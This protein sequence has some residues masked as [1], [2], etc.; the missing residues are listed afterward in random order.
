MKSLTFQNF[1]PALVVSMFLV[2]PAGY[3]AVLE[4][5]VVTAQKRAE[6]LQDVPLAVTAYSGEEL[7][8]FGITNTQ[9]L[10]HVTASLLFHN[11]SSIAQPRI[12]GVGTILSLLGLEPS[13]AL[14]V[15]DQYYSRPI[16]AMMELP[17]VERIEILKGPQGTLYGRNATGGAIRIV[18]RDP[19]SEFGGRLNLS[20][21]N[22]GY[23]GG[24]LYVE[25]GL[26]ETLRASFST[27][28][29]DRDGFADNLAPDAGDV[30]DLNVQMYRGKLVW[31]A[32]DRVTAKLAIDYTDKEDTQGA[33]TFDIS[34]GGLSTSRVFRLPTGTDRED[35]YNDHDEDNEVENFNTQLR[36][37]ISFDA[38]DLVSITTYQD[39]TGGIG[40][41]F[42]AS[43]GPVVHTYSEENVES[44]SQE[45]QLISTGEG[46]LEWLLG[47]Y[48]LDSDGDFLLTIDRTVLA[49]VGLPVP[50][51]APLPRAD[52]K[53]EAW[54]IFGQATWNF[55]EQWGLTA[56]GRYSE[57]KKDIV[58]SSPLF[59]PFGGSIG[60]GDKWTEFTPKVTL[61]YNTDNALYYFTYAAG[62]KSGGYEYPML[63]TSEA[64][65]P[66]TL[67]M[68]E[69]GVKADLANDSLR[70]AASFYYYDYTDLQLNRNAQTGA[71]GVAISVPV[72]NVGDA[73]VIGLD[74][75]ATWLASEAL[76]FTGGFTWL[77]TKHTSFPDAVATA[78]NPNVP[79]RPFPSL[80]TLGYDASGDDL[81]RTPDFAAFVAMEY[82]LNVGNGATMP[83]NVS[84]SFKDKFN[85]N[86]VSDLPNAATEL[87][88]DSVSLVNARLSYVPA[89]K[90]WS[91]SMWVNNLTD[92]E[93]LDEAVDFATGVRG[94]GGAPRTFGGDISFNF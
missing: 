52:L 2:T 66:E 75:D 9:Q 20:A 74:L 92:E 79:P 62:F 7:T 49:R 25:G 78:W 82:V 51:V 76:T 94:S 69:L 15:D 11:R 21:G 10:Q 12:R 13:I 29:R 32:T 68:Y 77:D 39:F 35:V 54:A 16:G 3:G 24:S 73:E 70:L 18:T 47:G 4:E 64:I 83:L 90:R 81:L 43:A 27:L 17:D 71:G 26:S 46:Q 45:L 40:G 56:G 22:Y 14:Y 36:L 55:N 41:D 60:D 57:E 85:F 42:D 91:V 19:A 6:S 67:D 59:A 50:A 28:V 23:L 48:Y 37:D 31:D 63:P 1:V 88:H 33:E 72:D 58:S 61:E 5:V 8:N 53:T 87:R 30:D 34:A 65:D 86:F 93:Y 44:V 84:Y 89:G 38:M 80:L